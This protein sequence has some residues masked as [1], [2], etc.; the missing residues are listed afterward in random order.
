MWPG[1]TTDVTTLDQVAARL[2][3]RFGVVGM[4]S[5]KMIAAVEAR[6]WFYIGGT[7]IVSG[8]TA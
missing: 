1:N 4:I 5:K 2:Q 8:R 3:S 7:S 6:G